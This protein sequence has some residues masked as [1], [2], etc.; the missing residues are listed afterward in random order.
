MRE[1][2]GAGQQHLKALEHANR[3]RLARADMK[4]QIADGELSVAE[5]VLSCPW[6]AESMSISSLL[7]SQKR[8]GTA[9]CRR[10]LKPIGVAENRRVGA[11]TERQR[12]AL[13]DALRPKDGSSR[14]RTDGERGRDEGV[15][16]PA[17]EAAL[18]VGSKPR[19]DRGELDDVAVRVAQ[20]DRL[21]ELPL[22]HLR[23]RRALSR[24]VVAPGP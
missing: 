18:L 23:A 3:V 11:L 19:R 17:R 4:R 14:R 21:E 5:V 2:A 1:T 22:E 7:T 15:G 10:T 8:W 16:A 13:A 20:I 12:I 9:R 6:H 24:Q